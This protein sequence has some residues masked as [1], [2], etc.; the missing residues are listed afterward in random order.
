[1]IFTFEEGD[2]KDLQISIYIHNGSGPSDVEFRLSSKDI[3]ICKNRETEE[4]RDL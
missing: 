2:L 4:K 1:M 3:S